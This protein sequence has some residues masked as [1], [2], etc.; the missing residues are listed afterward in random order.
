MFV[1]KFLS[2]CYQVVQLFQCSPY[3]HVLTLEADP[4]VEAALWALGDF[5]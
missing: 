3:V 4:A 5:C 2:F 1:V